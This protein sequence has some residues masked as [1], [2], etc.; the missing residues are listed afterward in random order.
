V[1]D[2]I[3]WHGHLDDRTA[4]LDAL[5]AADLFVFPSPAEGFPKVILDAAA[6]GLPILASPVGALAELAAMGLLVPVAP[7]DPNALAAAVAALG[8][9]AR[10]AARLRA[11]GLRFAARH[12]R[13][14]EAERLVGRLRAR[15]P[16]LPWS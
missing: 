14:A 3:I 7:G 6:A 11:L 15:Y 9:D 1:G 12:T 8:S 4:Y 2:R 10:R 13:P 16:L 5:G